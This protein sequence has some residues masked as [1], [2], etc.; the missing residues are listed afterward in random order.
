MGPVSG[1]Q[2]DERRSRVAKDH[3]SE[4]N[5]LACTIDAAAGDLLALK[6]VQIEVHPV[7][8]LTPT[9]WTARCR[10]WAVS[11]GD[12]QR[13]KGHGVAF[14][15][16][17]ELAAMDFGPRSSS[18]VGVPAQWRHRATTRRVSVCPM[19]LTLKA[20]ASHAA[21]TGWVGAGQAAAVK[22]IKLKPKDKPTERQKSLPN[23]PLGRTRLRPLRELSRCHWVKGRQG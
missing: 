5:R 19:I 12:M 23:V 8:G 6:K 7:R 1:L 22:A 17:E 3:P 9:G 18:K 2:A 13:S 15:S 10:D 16:E 20:T 4:C 21:R 11:T 14:L